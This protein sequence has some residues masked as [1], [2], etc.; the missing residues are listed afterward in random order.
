MIADIDELIFKCSDNNSK[1][2]VEEAVK[3][4]KAG[5][6]RACINNT[7][8]ALVMNITY[9]IE[10]LALMD[11]AEA[12][13][14]KETLDKIKESN[15]ISGLLKYE[16]NILDVAKEKFEFFDDIALI[17]LERIKKDRNRCSHP[18]LNMDDEPFIPSAELARHHLYFAVE[19]VIS[20]GNVFGKTAINKILD[21]INSPN[22]PFLYDDVETVLKNSYLAKPKKSLVTN[23]TKI[24]IKD[25]LNNEN[26]YR[27]GI[28][29]QN[30]LRFLLKSSRYIVEETLQDSLNTLLDGTNKNHLK[31]SII[32]FSLDK[33]FWETLSADIQILIQQYVQ[34][35]PESD[36]NNIDNWLNID[37]TAEKAR[38]RI[39]LANRRELMRYKSSFIIPREIRKR[40]FDLYL[41]SNSF[42]EANTFANTVSLALSDADK[43]E[44][45]IFISKIHENNQVF[46]S[47]KLISVISAIKKR[48]LF[49]SEELNES[50]EAN[51]LNRFVED[52]FDG[53]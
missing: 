53:F 44:I 11:D 50:F 21:L 34:I 35:I 3:S 24:L 15:N 46:N 36:F 30:V 43:N 14:Q 5:A 48:G 7:W 1:M 27:I 39:G 16:H 42:D 37:C 32:L 12:M 49:S 9:K 33:I 41:Q 23:L 4:Y 52:L 40:I 17:D 29:Y 18:L 25:I 8:L 22:F 19:K 13:K 47:N 45:K 6:Y 26:N 20:E 38:M 10:Q 51:G 28:S 31:N 2:F